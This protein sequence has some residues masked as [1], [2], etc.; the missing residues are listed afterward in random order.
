MVKPLKALFPD[1]PRIETEVMAII[2]HRF[3]IAEP[4]DFTDRQIKRADLIALATEKRDL[5]PRSSEAWESLAGIAPL[6]TR[7]EAAVAG[8]GQTAVSGR[9]S[10]ASRA[11]TARCGLSV[12]A[13]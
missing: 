12:G 7:I 3:G 1:F 4:A 2:G 11:G 8:C 10:I 9:G 13:C 5:M 6:P